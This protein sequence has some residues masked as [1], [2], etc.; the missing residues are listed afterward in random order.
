MEKVNRSIYTYREIP[1]I[2]EQYTK[3]WFFGSRGKRE[4]N[5]MARQHDVE[6]LDIEKFQNAI[7]QLDYKRQLRIRL[8]AEKAR[9]EGAGRAGDRIS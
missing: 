4:E 8:L 5:E 9:G 7:S 6:G 3:L 2:E 1:Y